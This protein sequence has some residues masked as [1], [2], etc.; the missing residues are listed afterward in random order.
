VDFRK[1]RAAMDDINYS[2]WIQIEG[3][4]PPGKSILESYKLNCAFMREVFNA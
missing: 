3:A 1:V 4:V 2:G